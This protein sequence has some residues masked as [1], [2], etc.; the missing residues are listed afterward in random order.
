MEGF[1]RGAAALGVKLNPAQVEQFRLYCDELLA[2]NE[3]TNLTA[4]TDTEAIFVRHF[5]DSLSVLPIMT[6]LLARDGASATRLIDVGTGAGFPGLPLR[7]ARPDFEVTLVDSVGKK[8]AFCS[9]MRDLLGLDGVTVVTGRAEDVGQQPAHREQYD[10][11]ISRAVAALPVLAEYLL[12]LCRLG[13]IAVAMK[14]RDVAGEVAQSQQALRLLGGAVHDVAP[15]TVPGLDARRTVIVMEK[16]HPTPPRYPR[17]AGVAA[18][19]PL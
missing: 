4:I 18:R 2:W 1:C 19:R 13:G 7:I 5:L 15:V 3:R 12:P 8:S 10:V 6:K 14:G 11:A 17:K 9:H 16:Q